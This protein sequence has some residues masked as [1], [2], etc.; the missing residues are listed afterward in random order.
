RQDIEV[1]QIPATEIAVELANPRG[2][3]IAMLG[4]LIAKTTLMS[5]EAFVKGLDDFFSSKGKA[6]PLNIKCFEKSY[7]LAKEQ[8]DG[9]C[10]SSCCRT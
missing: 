7:E 9:G 6:N 2:A 4:A 3:N 10:C 5:K 8:S 1:I